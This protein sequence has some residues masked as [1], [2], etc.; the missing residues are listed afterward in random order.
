M[1]TAQGFLSS[2]VR[3]F[4]ADVGYAGVKVFGLSLSMFVRLLILHCAFIKYSGFFIASFTVRIWQ[5]VQSRPTKKASHLTK[6][7]FLS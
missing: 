1:I 7:Q 2:E 5:V 4:K 6:D 3:S